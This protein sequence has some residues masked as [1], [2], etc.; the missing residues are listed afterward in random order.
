MRAANKKSFESLVL[1]GGMDSFKNTHRAQYFQ[2]SGDGVTFLEKIIKYGAKYQENLNSSQVSLFEGSSEEVISEP[3]IPPCE[4]WGTL[5]AL[6]QE[7]EVVGIYISAHPLDDFK[8]VLNSFCN[9]SVAIF[10]D[11]NPLVNRELTLGGIVGDVQHR[12]SKNGKGWAIF[13]LEDYTDSYDFRI[14]GEEYLKFKHF[15]VTNNFVHIKVFVKE[16]WVNRETG[17]KG[18]PRLQFNVFQQLQDTLSSNSKKITLQLNINEFDEN[19]LEGLKE[20]LKAH[21][22]D[23]PVD[24]AFFE[25]EKK[26]KLVMHSRNQK[27]AI[28]ENFLIDLTASNFHYKLN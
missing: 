1:A 5:H 25:M 26:L 7:R 3:E 24:I 21:K 15:L 17:K 19:K 11:L 6:K 9:A 8:V 27:V 28:T 12:V 16:G 13:T 20:V 4:P 23:R 2:D 14:F 18:D 22:G 10:S